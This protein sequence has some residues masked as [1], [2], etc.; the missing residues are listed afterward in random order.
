MSEPKLKDLNQDYWLP[1]LNSILKSDVGKTR[2]KYM[3]AVSFYYIIAKLEKIPDDQLQLLY[4]SF[5]GFK[6]TQDASVIGINHVNDQVNQ[7]AQKWD[8]DELADFVN[9]VSLVSATNVIAGMSAAIKM[10][11]SL[12]ESQKNE[13]IQQIYHLDMMD[14]WYG[15]RPNGSGEKG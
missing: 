3:L 5:I 6:D 13:L 10:N 7:I 2:S 4:K 11:D 15:G 1:K 14:M 8:V 9:K 12:T